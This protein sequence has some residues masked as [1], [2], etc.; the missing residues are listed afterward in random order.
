MRSSTQG[1]TEYERGAGRLFETVIA[2][3][4]AEVGFGDQVRAALDAGLAL[5]ASEPELADLVALQPYECGQSLLG[6][7]LSWVDRYAGLLRRA[8][9]FSP[10][11]NA[12]PSFVEPAL[13]GGVRWQIADSVL[14]DRVVQLPELAPKLTR[15]V[16]S[17][18]LPPELAAS[19]AG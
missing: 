9:R 5:L 11:A 19:F 10:E 14:A 18:Y 13:L 4:G 16:L 8:A 17:Y 1:Q 2:A 12:N 6:S 15:F 7:H 3:G